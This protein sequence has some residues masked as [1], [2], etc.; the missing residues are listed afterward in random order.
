MQLEEIERYILTFQI[1]RDALQK[2]FYS[3]ERPAEVL[4][5]YQTHSNAAWPRV[6]LK[7]IE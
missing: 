2:P 6:Y 7:L 3:T 1:S 5:H 4:K